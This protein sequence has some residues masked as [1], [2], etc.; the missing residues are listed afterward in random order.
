[1]SITVEFKDFEEMKAFARELLGA[2]D[3]KAA[4]TPAA[5][6]AAPTMPAPGAVTAQAAP[7]TP[8]PSVPVPQA[9]PAAPAA[10]VISPAA[11]VPQVTPAAPAVPTTAQ[12]YTMDDLARAGM[13]LM[14]AGRQNDLIQLLAR[15]GVDTL[16]ALPQD[17]YGAFATALREM[18]AKI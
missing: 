18:G 8:L 4:S 15:F 7:A 11:P 12:T 10:P 3:Q 1:M 13:G 6:Q 17:Q 16:P 9:A 14:D 2:V 5:T